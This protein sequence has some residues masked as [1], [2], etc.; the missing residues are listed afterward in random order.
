[1]VILLVQGQDYTNFTSGC[2]SLK[3]GNT[4]VS[5]STA[6]ILMTVPLL[7]SPNIPG[8]FTAS[9]GMPRYM[10]E[11]GW[12]L[13]QHTDAPGGA[14]PQVLLSHT[15]QVYECYCCCSVA[16]LCLTLCHP[17]GCSTPGFPVPRYLLQFAQVHVH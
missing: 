13:H 9:A 16:E 8:F 15:S 3:R 17:M 11:T 6:L 4:A 14:S 2:V 1:M 10:V 7:C 5:V 12:G